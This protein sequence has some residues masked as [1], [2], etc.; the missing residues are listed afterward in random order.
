MENL[1]FCIAFGVIF[2]A[3]M[4]VATL[5]YLFVYADKII[6]YIKEK[7]GKRKRKR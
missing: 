6:E 1:I 3:L 4:L 5:C 7:Y 2:I